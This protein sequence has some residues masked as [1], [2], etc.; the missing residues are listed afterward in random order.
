VSVAGLDPSRERKANALNIGVVFGQRSQLW[1]DLPLRESFRA[2]RDLY[3]VPPMEGDRRQDE[4]VKLLDMDEFLD[5]PVRQLSLGQ[6]MRGDLAAAMLCQPR[7][8]FLD[9]P[10]VGLDVVAKQRIREFVAH[11]NAERGTTV[12]LTTHDLE[13]VEQLC[14][15]IVLIDHGRVLYDGALTELMARY[16]PH[17]ELVVTLADPTDVAVEGAEQVAREGPVVTLRFHS[18]RVKAP[19]IIAAVTAA[20]AVIDLSVVEPRLE[21]VIGRIYTQ[22]GLPERPA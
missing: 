14:R 21:A 20:R 12:V 18:D 11:A 9:E 7:L 10:T 3:G 16:A 22:R 5:A 2:I 15:R 8:L 1:W 4:L 19:E 17:R 6:R 13:D